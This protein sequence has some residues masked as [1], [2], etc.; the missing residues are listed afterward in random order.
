[1]QLLVEPS[2]KTDGA[3]CIHIAGTRAK[4]ESVESVKDALIP[5]YLAGLIGR[6]RVRAGPW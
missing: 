5:L 2:L 1:M 6:A 4:G 3:D